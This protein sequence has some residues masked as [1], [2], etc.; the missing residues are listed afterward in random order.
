MALVADRIAG[1]VPYADR[2]GLWVRAWPD[3]DRALIA[4]DW[5]PHMN[6]TVDLAQAIASLV[7]DLAGAP[8]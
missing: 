4:Q 7:Q 2:K 3:P 8:H 1:Y 6:G 5:K